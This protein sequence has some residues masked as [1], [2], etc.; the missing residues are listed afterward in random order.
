[1]ICMYSVAELILRTFIW[2][3]GNLVENSKVENGL[4]K[5]TLEKMFLSKNRNKKILF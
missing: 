5:P 2:C 1:M 3:E 4:K